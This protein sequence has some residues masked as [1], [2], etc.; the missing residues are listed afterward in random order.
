MIPRVASHRVPRDRH[1]FQQLI[2]ALGQEDAVLERA[3]LP[4]VGVAEDVTLLPGGVRRQ[5]PFQ[6]RR[7][8]GAAA[9]PQPRVLDLLDHFRGR[10]RERLPE[11]A[12]RVEVGEVD[13]PPHAD[14]VAHHRAHQGVFVV[15]VPHHRDQL[16]RIQVPPQVPHQ[17][18]PPFG[19]QMRHHHRVDE[20][21]RRLVAHPYAGRVGEGDGAVRSRFPHGDAEFPGHG[22]RDGL[23]SFH[24]VD[25]VA[26]EAYDD[27][28]LR[29]HR[30]ERVERHEAFDFH[31]VGLHRA[32]DLLHGLVR[33]AAE[34]FLH[35]DGDVHQTGPVVPELLADLGGYLSRPLFQSCLPGR[36]MR[37]SVSRTA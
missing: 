14:V 1:P 11:R 20:R 31:P 15:P 13:R 17:L 12:S 36:G 2:G 34:P 32:G 6:A 19:R 28:P 5:L 21:R 9:S 24:P 22:F 23:V 7:E 33:H 27:L 16:L 26:A 8:T 10:K 30:Q 18:P 3:R 29:L 25:D 37:P 35:R 4:L